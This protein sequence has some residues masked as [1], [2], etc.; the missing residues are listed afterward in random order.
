MSG[1]TRSRFLKVQC[2]DC[3]NEQ[4]V[5]DRASNK[6]KCLVCDKLVAEPSGGKAKIQGEVTQVLDSD[7][8]K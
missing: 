1:K 6:V 4:T 5:F 8:A 2:S 7:L 3:G